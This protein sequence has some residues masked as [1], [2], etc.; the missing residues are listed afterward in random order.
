MVPSSTIESSGL[1]SVKSELSMMV[2][3]ED[4][5][6]T[7]YCEA[8]YFVPGETRMTETNKINITVHCEFH[9]LKQQ[10]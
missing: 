6:A 2:K 8:S 10:I 9:T 1:F 3:K 4:K 5:D 7:F